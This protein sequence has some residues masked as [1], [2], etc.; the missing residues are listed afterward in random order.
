MKHIKPALLI[1]VLCILVF[2]SCKKSGSKPQTPAVNLSFKF[3]GTAKNTNLVVADYIKSQQSLQV[4]GKIGTGTEGLSLLIENIKVGSFDLASGTIIA[5][6][7]T[8]SDFADTYLGT[9]GTVT[10]TSFTTDAVAGTFQ[11]AGTKPN[12]DAGTITEGK[13]YAKL[14]TQ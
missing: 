14:I 8:T 11:F 5:S 4:M 12:N 1:L 2:S 9:T 13:F 6:Y 7:S 10:I 3:N